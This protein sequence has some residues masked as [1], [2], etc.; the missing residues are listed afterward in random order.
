M[1]LALNM[2]SPGEVSKII[3]KPKVKHMS[4]RVQGW[5]LTSFRAQTR[6]FQKEGQ[7]ES[8]M[9]SDST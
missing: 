2:N 5:I 8:N 3:H 7:S 6:V 9:K 4:R 1:F